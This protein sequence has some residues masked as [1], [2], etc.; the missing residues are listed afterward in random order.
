M[1]VKTYKLVKRCAPKYAERHFGS[2][3][4]K[5]LSPVMRESFKKIV[6][7]D[8]REDAEKIACPVLF[9]TGER[10]EETPVSSAR[11]YASAVEGSSL[12]IMEN[13]GHFAH[14]D[15]PLRFNLAAEEFFSNV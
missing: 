6:N 3:E 12:L 8:L 2:A 10:D 4:Y 9:I 7:E 5:M 14:L 15:D 1:R 11:I 13:C